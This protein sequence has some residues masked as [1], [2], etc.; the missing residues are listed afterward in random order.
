MVVGG[1]VKSSVWLADL[2]CRDLTVGPTLTSNR[3]SSMV[4]YSSVE[5]STAQ[6]TG[7]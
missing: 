4:E 2:R 6:P 1:V 5:Y 3:E 7:H